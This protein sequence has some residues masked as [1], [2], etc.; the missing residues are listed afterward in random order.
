MI[1]QPAQTVTLSRQPTKGA[2]K[3]RAIWKDGSF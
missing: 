2:V 1:D 3:M